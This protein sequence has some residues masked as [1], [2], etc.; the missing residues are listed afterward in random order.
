MHD[1]AVAR[2][3][4]KVAVGST[5]ECWPWLASKMP[6]GYGQFRS[7]AFRS[8]LAHRTAYELRCAA[9]PA[10]MQIDH[11]CRNRACVNPAHME[12]VTAQE[13]AR[14]SQPWA[15]AAIKKRAATRQQFKCGHPTEGDHVAIWSGKR[16]CRICARAHNRRQYLRRKERL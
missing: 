9:I 5:S 6:N 3:W 13:N 10:G 8:A 12:P 4:A 15:V 1:E 14:R 7:H 16:A 2:F 11:L